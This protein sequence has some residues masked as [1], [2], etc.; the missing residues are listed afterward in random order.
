MGFN[1]NMPPSVVFGPA[2]LGGIGL[3]HLYI[4][5]GALKTTALIERIRQH[6]RLGQ[7]MWISIQWAQVTAGVGFALLGEP[8]CFLP[9][10]VGTWFLSLRDFLADSEF[11]LE[12]ANT[13]A[14]S[15][16]RDH[17]R[18][19]MDDALTGWNTDS[20]IQAINGCRL[21]LQVEC[22][23]DICTADGRSGT[24]TQT[25]HSHLDEHDAVAATGATW[26]KLVG[27]MA[28]F[29][30]NVYTNQVNRQVTDR[31]RPMDSTPDSDLASKL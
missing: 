20:N 6:G 16:R 24:T 9:H 5:Q 27:S 23:S 30:S 7:T 8:D 14:V 25:T 11:T 29:H 21:Y 28:T 26:T 17:D 2:S 22:L 12:V 1:Q 19:L 3:L 13:Y 15:K 31:P 4:V 10:A 18:I